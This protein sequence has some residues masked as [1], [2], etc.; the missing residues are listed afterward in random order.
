M[1][2]TLSWFP[3]YGRYRVASKT[4]PKRSQGSVGSRLQAPVGCGAV[5]QATG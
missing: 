1:L 5:S 4:D 3:S 2:I